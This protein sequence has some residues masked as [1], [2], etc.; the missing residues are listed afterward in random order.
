M[1]KLK[2][3]YKLPDKWIALYDDDTGNSW[4]K[5]LN[6][7][8]A[9][10]VAKNVPGRRFLSMFDGIEAVMCNEGAKEQYLFWSADSEKKETTN[11]SEECCCP[12]DNFKFNGIGCVC[13]AMKK[14]EN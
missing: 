6:E 14:Q 11:N 13:G 12:Y 3:L 2:K 4:T 8:L 9:I 5:D 7:N 10:D 1:A